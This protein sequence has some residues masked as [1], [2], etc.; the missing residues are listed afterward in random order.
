MA[1]S[2]A[3]RKSDL[4]EEVQPGFFERQFQIKRQLRLGRRR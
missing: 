2:S 4:L 3:L 1:L